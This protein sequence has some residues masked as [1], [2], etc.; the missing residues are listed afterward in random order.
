MKFK[1]M[2]LE[3]KSKGLNGPARMGRVGSSKTGETLYYAGR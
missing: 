1:I 2:Y 3:D